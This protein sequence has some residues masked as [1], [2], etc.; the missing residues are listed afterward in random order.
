MGDGRNAVANITM[1]KVAF[2]DGRMRQVPFCRT[3]AKFFDR[4]EALTLHG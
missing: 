4:S 3:L 2:R 1:F